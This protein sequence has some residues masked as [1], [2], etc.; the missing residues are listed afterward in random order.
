MVQCIGHV[1]A[2]TNVNNYEPIGND[3]IICT[4]NL[5]VCVKNSQLLN[6]P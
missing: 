1:L 4:R 6:N 2:I 3:S 5:H